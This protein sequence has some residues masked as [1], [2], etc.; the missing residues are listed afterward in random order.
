MNKP[1]CIRTTVCREYQRLLE[2]CQSALEIWDEHRVEVCESRLFRKEAGVELLRLQDEPAASG[3]RHL[4]EVVHQRRHP[5][6]LSLYGP[7]V[8][9]E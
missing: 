6:D 5:I 3:T 7:E 2:D 1:Q 9:V 4:E 8:G